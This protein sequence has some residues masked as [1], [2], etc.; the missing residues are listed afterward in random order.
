MKVNYRRPH[1]KCHI[2]YPFFPLESLHDTSIQMI[3]ESLFCMFQTFFLVSMCF[4]LKSLK[5]TFFLIS[6]KQCLIPHQGAL[7][8]GFLVTSYLLNF[9]G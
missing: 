1:L 2:K 3:S 7:D 4:K 6:Q 9:I 8:I 5:S